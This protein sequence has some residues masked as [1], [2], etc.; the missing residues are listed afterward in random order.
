MNPCPPRERLEQFLGQEEPGPEDGALASHVDDCPACQEVLAGVLRSLPGLSPRAPDSTPPPR[1]GDEFLG[2]LRQSP[3]RFLDGEPGPAPSPDPN[4]LPFFGPPTSAAPLGRL[5]AYHLLEALG[6]GATGHVFKARDADLDRLVA[7]KVLKPELAADAAGRAAFEREARAAAAVR[8][9][10]V[11]TIH[12]VAFVPG[13]DLPYLV[14]EHVDGEPLSGRLRRQ[15]PLPPAEAARLVRQAAAGL[16][17]AHRKGLVHRDV[18][19]ANLLVEAGTG[20]VKVTDFGLAC[21]AAP[22]PA[23]PGAR[24]GAVVGTPAYMSPEQA[25]TPGR[26]DA[27]SD[28]YSLG[29]VLYELLLGEPPFRGP[30]P[31]ALR[32]AAQTPPVP[33]RL[34]DPAIPTGLEQIVLTCLAKEP[35]QRYQ[36]AD[37]L[38]DDLDRWRA[39]EAVRARPAGPLAR[40]GRWCRQHPGLLLAGT[41][42]AAAL[43]T[44]GLL[45]ALLTAEQARTAERLRREQDETRAARQQGQRL[46]ARLALDRG[47]A[48][49]EQ[50]EVGRGMLWLARALELA[51]ADDELQMTARLQLAAWRRQLHG[52]RSVLPH[53]GPVYAVAFSPDGRTLLTGCTGETAR[54]WDT[55]TGKLLAASPPNSMPVTGARFSPDGRTVLMRRQSSGAALWL[56]GEGSRRIEF[57]EPDSGHATAVAF[58]PD[59]RR[60]LTVGRDQV[61]RL[62]EAAT[63][64]LLGTPFRHPA[65]IVALAFSPDG[66]SVFVGGDDG[67]VRRRDMVDGTPVGPPLTH[68]GAITDLAISPDGRAVLTGSKDHTARLWDLATGEPLGPPFRHKDKVYAVAFGPDGRTVLTGSKDRTARL[69]DTD[70]GKPLGPPLPHPGVVHDVAFG[71]D[72]RAVL[73]GGD[74]GSARLWDVARPEAAERE[75]GHDGPVTCVAFAPDGNTLLIGSADGEVCRMD[76]AGGAVLGTL[77]H[78]GALGAIAFSPDGATVLLGS[79]GRAALLV[80][81]DSGQAL[82]PPLLHHERVYGVTFSPNGRTALTGGEDRVARLWDAATG[83]PLGTFGP[84]GGAVLAVAFSPDGHTIVT[85]SWDGTV[86]FW[87]TAAFQP[88]G[89]GLHHGGAVTAVAF[90]PDGRTL[91]TASRDST[92]QLWDVGTRRPLGQPLVHDQPVRCAAFSPDGRTVLTGGEDQTARWWD[93]ATGLPLGPPLRQ[94]ALVHAVAFAPDGRRVVLASNRGAGRLWEVPRPV[95]GPPERVVLWTQ[96]VTGLELDADERVRALDGRAWQERRWRLDDGPGPPLP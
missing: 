20:R 50:G 81:A 3:P 15:G 14:M 45:A 5:A 7:I 96:V 69:W 22:Q 74:D 68:Q 63:G 44:A 77:R 73:T 12:Q 17:H 52:L 8:H 89:E 2:C 66:R 27:R 56:T 37:A 6:S 72:G 58:S 49:C 38:I 35:G 39:G 10:H 59:G 92:A 42:T 85:G 93:A 28:V 24:A 54:L 78:G 80:G 25:L 23:G 57:V 75:L 40:L 26:I 91:L 11:V 95:E 36:T 64:K 46:L 19:P 29:V 53:E 65:A 88:S 76:G 1:P 71:P 41:V 86:R 21:A 32:H 48:L 67:T 18:K 94:P 47:Q 62:W 84:H 34:C 43:A 70:T 33:P 90:S 60:V 51:P 55:A 13:P 4:P 82:G 30:A 31:R 16:A 83:R 61:A 9:E 87:E 79:H